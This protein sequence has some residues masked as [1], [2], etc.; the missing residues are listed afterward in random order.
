MIEGA[1]Y[2]VIFLPFPGDVLGSVRIDAEGFATVYI[3]EALA[4]RA[5]Q[6]VLEHELRHIRRNDFYNDMSIYAV[7]AQ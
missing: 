5:R 4:P 7:E 3:N 6:E 2:R 1:D